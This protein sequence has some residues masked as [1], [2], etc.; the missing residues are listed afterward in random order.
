[1]INCSRRATVRVISNS[2]AA[3]ALATATLHAQSGPR[4]IPAPFGAISAPVANELSGDRARTTVGFVEQFFRL[5][6]NRGFDASIDTV[7]ALLTAAGYVP[8]S[9]AKATDRL[10]FRIES[11]PM[12]TQA[13]TPDAGVTAQ[14]IKGA[15]GMLAAQKL[16]AYNQQTKHTTAIQFTSIANDSVHR[17]FT[18]FLSSAAHRFPRNVLSIPHTC[19]NRARTTMRRGSAC[20]PKWPVRRP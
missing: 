3:F 20:S 8:E 11:R 9:R 6:G 2:C 13:W 14:V 17:G 10:I 7:A 12:S 19:R 5:P 1:M 16:P 15:L 4:V 18:I